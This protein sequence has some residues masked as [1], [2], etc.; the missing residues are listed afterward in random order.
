[1]LPPPL[2]PGL[3]ASLENSSRPAL[4]TQELGHLPTRMGLE[5]EAKLPLRTIS[6]ACVQTVGADKVPISLGSRVNVH[7]CLG[8]KA[9]PAIQGLCIQLRKWELQTT[10]EPEDVQDPR[11]MQPVRSGLCRDGHSAGA[12]GG[13]IRSFLESGDSRPRP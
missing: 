6:Q 11:A 7:L 2:C 13:E 3:L 4:S 8:F 1:M 12:R 10:P 5:G 9:A